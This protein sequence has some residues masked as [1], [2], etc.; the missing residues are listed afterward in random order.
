[1]TGEKF[2]LEVFR[3]HKHLMGYHDRMREWDEL[4][5]DNKRLVLIK[6]VLAGRYSHGLMQTTF[7]SVFGQ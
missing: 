4:S 5:D 3:A 1:M 7:Y 2:V 6:E